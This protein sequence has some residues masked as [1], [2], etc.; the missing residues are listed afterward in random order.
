MTYNLFAD[1]YDSLMDESFYQD[2]LTYINQRA[3][4]RNV[5]EFGCGT[6]RLCHLFPSSVDVLGVDLSS[7]MIEIAKNG[8]GHYVVGDMRTYEPHQRYD[9]ILCICDS[10]N[11]ILG[12][13]E[14][15]NALTH[16]LTFLNDDGLMIFDI[17]SQHHIDVTFENYVEENEDE[18]FYFYWKVFKS[19]PYQITH[20]VAIEDLNEDVR[21]EEK[22]IQESYPYTWY[23]TELEA[24]GYATHVIDE[25][26]R[27]KIEVWRIDK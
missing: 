13:Q 19:A 2:Y 3:S 27:I 21:M 11:Y 6:G 24:L 20:Y 8:H 18:D 1:Y 15:I 23:T 22:H 25:G 17:H 10:L 26:E 4:Y 16:M 12:F 5:L 9:L 7:E 14:Q